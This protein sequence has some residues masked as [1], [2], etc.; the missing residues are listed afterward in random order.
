M[1][2]GIAERAIVLV[3]AFCAHDLLS[4]RGSER[5]KNRPYS[6]KQFCFVHFD[7]FPVNEIPAL[8]PATNALADVDVEATPTDAGRSQH[9][10]L[11]EFRVND[12]A[13]TAA[14]NCDRARAKRILECLPRNPST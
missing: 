7:L 9:R 3:G 8:W 12:V 2:C 1:R 14:S 6:C 13:A 10:L 4:M 11:V 5:R